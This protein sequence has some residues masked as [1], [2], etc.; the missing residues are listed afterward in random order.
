MQAIAS[1][2]KHRPDRSHADD[3]LGYYL[4]QIGQHPLLERQEELELAVTLSTN[5]QAYLAH[6]LNNHLVLRQVVGILDDVV[7]GK[8]RLERTLN[9]A[10]TDKERRLQ[11]IALLRSHVPTL[12]HL[13]KKNQDDYCQ[14]VTTSDTLQPPRR[15]L[16]TLVRRRRKCVQLVVELDIRIAEIDPL[17][18]TLTELV[19]RGI[20]I[21]T[22]SREGYAPESDERQQ[23]L[24]L[25][26]TLLEDP[27]QTLKRLRRIRFFNRQYQLAKNQLAVANLRLVVSIAKRYQNKGVAFLDLIQ[28]GNAGLLRG[29]E[30]YDHTR[31]FRLS[32]YATWW[33]TQAVTR[34]LADKSRLVRLPINASR[35]VQAIREAA[36]QLDERRGRK[37]HDEATNDAWQAATMESGHILAA[38]TIPMS[39]D[40]PVVGE[41]DNLAGEFLV[42][43]SGTDP[44]VPAYHRELAEDVDQLLTELNDRERRII[45]LRF[46]FHDGQTHSLEEVGRLFGVSR[47]RVRQL[48]KNALKK[49]RVRG[50]FNGSALEA[51]VG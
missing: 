19:D 1:H 22:I 24:D 12:R 11:A 37:P 27:R 36:S 2:T 18:E 20:E 48:E 34:A 28:E 14:F 39:L 46:G 3:V 21:A 15:L 5:R 43:H 44:A 30:K 41:G 4:S 47:E 8:R 9:M 45:Q 35:K 13:L 7:Q 26:T 31:G 29:I 40:Q 25:G 49:L 33:I 23:L 10:T 16:Q 32:T 51:H 50:A 17:F 6:L 38:S 42:D